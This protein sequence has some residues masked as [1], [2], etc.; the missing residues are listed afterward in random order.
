ME[1]EAMP[2][3]GLIATF[4]IDNSMSTI[5]TLLLIWNLLHVGDHKDLS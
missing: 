5:T 3:N 4:Q 2:F 1:L